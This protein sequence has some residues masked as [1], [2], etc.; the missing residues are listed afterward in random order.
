MQQ[1]WTALEHVRPNHLGFLG[2][3]AGGGGAGS[4]SVSASFWR[5][6]ATKRCSFAMAHVVP[7]PP[8]LRTPAA[9]ASVEEGAAAGVRQLCAFVI[10][11]ITSQ[12]S[13]TDHGA[14]CAGPDRLGAIP[15]G[16]SG[17]QVRQLQAFVVS[18]L[19]Q[20]LGPAALQARAAPGQVSGASLSVHSKHGPRCSTNG[21]SHLGF[22]LDELWGCML[23][24][25][26]SG[27]GSNQPMVHAV[28]PG[29]AQVENT[30]HQCFCRRSLCFTASPCVSPPCLTVPKK[31]VLD[32]GATRPG[33]SLASRGRP[34]PAR[35][36]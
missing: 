36:W 17:L 29:P 32:S 24:L 28:Y 1:M 15:G 34:G 25:I 11:S 21:R 31:A 12:S 5:R 6:C 35:R 14:A 20:L 19:R 13:Q 27:S 22:W 18:V 9:G 16:G 26:T 8:K 23:A 2:S 10:T 30:C 7:P 4:M 33:C 3:V